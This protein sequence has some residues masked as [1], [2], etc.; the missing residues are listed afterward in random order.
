LYSS[1]PSNHREEMGK[2]VA[3]VGKIRKHTKFEAENLK[4]RE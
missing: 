1:P 3:H 2:Q 4:G